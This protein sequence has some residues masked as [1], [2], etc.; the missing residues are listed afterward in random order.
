M[1]RALPSVVTCIG[2]VLSLA[3]L[4]GGP[5]YVGLVGLLCDKLDGTLARRLGVSSDWGGL[6]DWL[7]D[8]T[9]AALVLDRLGVLPL[10]VLFVPLQ[11]ELRQRGHHV[12]GRALLM[13]IELAR[14]LWWG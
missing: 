10:A 12:S 4:Q 2:H 9:M 5:W 8:V 11:V 7:V 14:R 3:W 6:Y 1:K 13:G